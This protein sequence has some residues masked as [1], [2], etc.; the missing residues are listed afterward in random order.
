[1]NKPRST[2]ET[3]YVRKVDV[4]EGGYT[5]KRWCVLDSPNGKYPAGAYRKSGPYCRTKKDLVE[6]LESTR[7][8]PIKAVTI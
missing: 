4:E 5:V 6:H 2:P 8:H 3:V 1:M 7:Q